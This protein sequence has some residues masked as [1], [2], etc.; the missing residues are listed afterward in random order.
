ML[1]FEERRKQENQQQTQHT[2]GVD[3]GIWTRATLVGGEHS[4]LC[5]IPC[6]PKNR[7][8]KES[9]RWK[10]KLTRPKRKRYTKLPDKARAEKAEKITVNSGKNLVFWLS[11]RTFQAVVPQLA[12]RA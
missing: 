5:A 12:L 3:A 6:F 4:H 8:G 7:P 9:Q 1:V 2:Y 10:G 11:F